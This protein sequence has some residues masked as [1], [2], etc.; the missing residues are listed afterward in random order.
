MTEAET[1]F[2]ERG[3]MGHIVLNRPHVLNALAP[4]QFIELNR[5][6]AAWERDDSIRM[7][8]IEGAGERA[9]SAGGDIRAAWDARVRG[10]DGF[11]RAIFREEY[12]MDRRIHH[13]G[14]P[15]VALM[16]GI[17]MGGGAGASV[18]G[19]FRIATERTLFAMPETAI[20]FFPDV[21]ATHFLSRCPGRIGLYLGMTGTRLG[22]ADALWAGIATHYVP[23]AELGAL[24]EALAGAAGAGDPLAA[25]ED[26]LAT[27][28]RDPGPAPLAERAGA[29]E[30]CFAAGTPAEVAALL[31]EERGTWA[32]QALASFAANS[33]TAIAVSFRQLVAGK[34]LC[35]DDA[36]RQEFRLACSFVAGD[37]FYEGIRALVIDKDRAPRWQPASF[38]DIEPSVLDRLFAGV[39]DEL[40]FEG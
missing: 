39:G 20:G 25:I 22:P 19:R 28:H 33:P 17:V 18:N 32:A 15:Y 29:V 14:K 35:F 9:F 7:V 40:G 2:T 12:R 1:L 11:T 34:T 27:S 16:D 10:D 23:A 38:A 37:E 21:G 26:V 31:G 36:I 24:K 30:R 3:G 6:L 13:Y 5:R 8:L 4:A